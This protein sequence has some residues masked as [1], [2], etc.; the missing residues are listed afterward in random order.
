MGREGVM[1]SRYKKVWINGKSMDEHRLIAERRAG[2]KLVRF[3]FVHHMNGDPRDNRLDNLGIVTAEEHQRIHLLR[4]PLERPCEMC[5]RMFQT[6]SGRRWVR[7]CSKTCGGYALR[8]R[9][10]KTGRVVRHY[11]SDPPSALP[12]MKPA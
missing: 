1:A 7:T 8:K 12:E 5:G 6:V 10:L 2:R 3:E 9:S 11:R 4:Y